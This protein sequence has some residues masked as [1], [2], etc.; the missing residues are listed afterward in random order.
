MLSYKTTLDQMDDRVLDF[1]AG[2]LDE[3]AESM[4]QLVCW[5]EDA[6]QPKELTSRDLDIMLKPYILSMSALA[7]GL[8]HLAIKEAK[9]NV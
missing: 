7:E 4:T 2:E 8:N 5:Y 9:H 1:L 6:A 3:L